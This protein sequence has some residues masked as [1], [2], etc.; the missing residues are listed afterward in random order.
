MEE[1]KLME[2]KLNKRT[3]FEQYR[4][5]YSVLVFL[6]EVWHVA[7]QYQSDEKLSKK[8]NKQSLIMGWQSR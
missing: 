3:F 2:K 8:E 7:E 4:K 6:L 5:V 1:L